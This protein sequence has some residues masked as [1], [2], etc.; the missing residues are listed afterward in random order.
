MVLTLVGVNSFNVYKRKRTPLHLAAENGHTQ[1]VLL[2]LE[3]KAEIDS[4]T[5]EYYIV[6]AGERSMYREIGHT[7][8]IFAIKNGHLETA[9]ILLDN[10]ACPNSLVKRFGKITL[11]HYVSEEGL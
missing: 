2:L 10:N 4:L 11:L 3:H 7:P 9:K 6:Q 8:L 1:T 5:A